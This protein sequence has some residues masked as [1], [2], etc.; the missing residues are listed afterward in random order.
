[1]CS[2]YNLCFILD[3]QVS[4]PSI[5]AFV[6]TQSLT[7]SLRPLSLYRLQNYLHFM[8][9]EHTRQN[10]PLMIDEHFMR[11]QT[12]ILSLNVCSHR[13]FRFGVFLLL[14]DPIHC[15]FHHYSLLPHFLSQLFFAYLVI[16]YLLDMIQLYDTK[17]VR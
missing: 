2:R 5:W 11:S 13:L 3:E 8:C 9:D 1:M 12:G 14:F 6:C 4:E 17:E 10:F 15:H 7:H 16:A